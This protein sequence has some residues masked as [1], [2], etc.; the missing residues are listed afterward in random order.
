FMLRNGGNDF[1]NTMFRDA[2]MQTVVKDQMDLD[3]LAYEPKSVYINGNYWGIMNLREKIDADYFKTVYGVEDDDLDLGEGTRALEGSIGTFSD[4]LNTLESMDL[5]GDEA[6][7]IIDNTIDVQEFIN[8]ITTEIYF[9]NTDWP[10]NNLKFWRQRSVN[11]KWR[12]VLW[13]L[14]FGMGLYPN[15]SYATHPTLH[16]ATEAN[17]PGWPNPPWAT[18]HMR[19]LLQNPQF[20]TRLIQTMAASLSTTFQP[21][22]VNA[23]IGA[24]QSKIAPEMPY[25]TARWS[26][27]IQNWN[28]EVQRIRDFNMQRNE[29]MKSYIAEFFQLED[30]V[31][32]NFQITP[33][34]GSFTLNGIRSWEAFT[35][36]TYF[37]NLPYVLHASADPGYRFSHWNVRKTDASPVNMINTGST[38][39][40]SDV[41]M[42]PGAGWPSTDYDDSSW[43]EGAAQLGYGEGDEQTVVGFGPDV[44]N[45]FPT[46]YFRKTITVEDTTAFTALAGK[47]LF[48]DGVIVYLNGNE[49]FRSNMPDGPVAYNTYATTAAAE[50]AFIP[51]SVPKGAVRPGTNVVA[52]EIHQNGPMSSDISFDLELKTTRLGNDTLYVLTNDTITGLAHADMTFEAVFEPGAAKQGIVINEFSARPTSLLDEKNDAEDWIELLNTG[53]EPVDIAGFFVTDN[54]G[55]KTK[56]QIKEGFGSATVLDPGQYKILWADEEI[57]EGPQH[58]NLKLSA[59][60]E[61]IGIYQMVGDEIQTV[62]EVTYAAYTS[63]GTYS[64]IPNGIGPFT[65][66]G[67][68]T[69]LGENIFELPTAISEDPD[70]DIF[71]YPNPAVADLHLHARLP[72]ESLQILNGSGQVVLHLKKPGEIISVGELPAG[73]Y[74]VIA[75]T[76]GGLVIRRFCKL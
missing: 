69:P 17:G 40:Y 25:H 70:D 72:V 36:V 1:W 48:D 61:S 38:W 11:G 4:Y 52:V 34:R 6:F 2:L 23:L 60:G 15:V 21:A 41:G 16:F 45:K 68:P 71:V 59:D 43:S 51:F 31:E 56:F 47:I 54:L 32:M 75:R 57:G 37:R 26:Q 7:T 19:L 22:R 39:R 20:R 74:I 18:R 46:T 8:Y 44:D 58:L 73:L 10:G 3:Y 13:D 62:D 66:T 50:N 67:Q 64:R 14:D 53:T 9:C 63:I 42:D 28:A 35:D 29:F 5:S 30:P 24:F 76:A 49:V 55:N 27:S 65:L 12:W 33:A